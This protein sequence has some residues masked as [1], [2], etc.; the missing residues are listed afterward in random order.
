VFKHTRIHPFEYPSYIPT[1]INIDYSSIDFIFSISQNHWSYQVSVVLV[2][3][4]LL[5]IL[6]IWYDHNLVRFEK[7]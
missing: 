7:T 1:Q 5:T 3:T 4:I 2:A 6:E